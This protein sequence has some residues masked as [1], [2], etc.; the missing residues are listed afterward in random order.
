MD[1]LFIVRKLKVEEESHFWCIANMCNQTSIR[2][3]IHDTQQLRI[4]KVIYPLSTA[5]TNE[6]SNTEVMFF[7]RKLEGNPMWCYLKEINTKP[8][9]HSVVMQ[10]MG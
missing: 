6:A 4:K 9:K 5:N 2:K 7:K 10:R 8:E 1:A 3:K